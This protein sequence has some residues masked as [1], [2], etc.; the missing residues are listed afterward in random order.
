MEQLLEGNISVKAAILG[1]HRK[2]IKLLVDQKK[3][4]KDTKFILRRAKEQGIEIASVSREIIDAIANGNTHGGLI[5]LCE[6]RAMQELS[7]LLLQNAQFLAIIEGVEDPYNFGYVL[8]SLYAA[9]CDGV[10]VPKRNWTSAAGI[11]AKAS[12]G[13]S[14]YLSMVSAEHM[15]YM[16]SELKHSGIPLVCAIRSE[17]SQNIY[18][19]RFPER[20]CLAIG[21][22]MRGL[23]KIVTQ[24]ADQKIFIP[25]A[26]DFRN[27]MSAASSTA[28]L[29]FEYLRQRHYDPSLR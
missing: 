29:S 8:R 1:N 19:Y 21:G 3:H 17:D 28:I 4:D 23:S 14:E 10:I 18:E 26:N 25:Y 20:F 7:S 22:E 12:A 5:A 13:A 15:S 11:V 24:N 27:A 6:E 2:V 9:G 16:I